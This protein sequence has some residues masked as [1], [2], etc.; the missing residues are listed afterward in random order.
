MIDLF[1]FEAFCV[2]IDRSMF[3][4]RTSSKPM[5]MIIHLLVTEIIKKKTGIVFLLLQ[6]NTDVI[7]NRSTICAITER[8]SLFKFNAR[9]YTRNSLQSGT[10]IC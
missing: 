9:V 7:S 4:M 5:K 10:S 1:D 6:M 8:R 3:G 2:S